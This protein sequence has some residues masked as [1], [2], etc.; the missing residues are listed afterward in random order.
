MKMKLLAFVIMLLMVMGG[1][2]LYAQMAPSGGQ[3]GPPPG[4]MAM[5]PEQRLQ[6]MTKQLNLSE[7]QQQKIKPI[8][9]QESQ[10]MQALRADSA[11]SQQDRHSK[12]MEIRQNSMSQIMPILNPD[13]QKKWEEMQ[14]K[15]RGGPGQNPGQSQPQ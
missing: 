12:M 11:M 15:H 13:Q 2:A 4:G 10:Q 14:Q 1:G 5:S 3:G 9:E 6:H 8:L 7:D